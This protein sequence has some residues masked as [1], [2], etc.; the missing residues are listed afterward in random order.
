MTPDP[1][2][3][4]QPDPRPDQK[5]ALQPGLQ[6][7]FEL[8]FRVHCDVGPIQSLGSV[9][10]VE[11]RVVPILGGMVTAAETN[12]ALSGRILPGGAD[13]QWVRSDAIT[14]ISAHYVIQT[15]SGDAIEVESRGVR[16]GPPEVMARLARGETV[17]AT[18]YYF[19]TA[20][21]FRTASQ[22]PAVARL[23]GLVSFAL[24]QRQATQVLLGIYALK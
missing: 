24:G 6:P 15:G 9:A 3:A 12:S 14:E 11:R 20:V 2:L 7:E 21:R 10:G 13:W 19:R 22:H 4:S 23:N 17:D 16:H 8:L 18:R 1:L 5:A